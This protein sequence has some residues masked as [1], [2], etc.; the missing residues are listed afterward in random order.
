VAQRDEPSYADLVYEVLQTAGQPLTFAEI[1]ENVSRRRPITTNNPKATI[2]TVLGQGKQLISLGD[3]WYGYLPHLVQGSLL[4][5]PLTE[6]GPGN[7]PLIYP[8]ELRQ[9][10]W[11]S[12]FESQKRRSTRAASMR[13]PNGVEVE[14]FL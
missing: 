12:F 1:F 3:G 5:Q 8:D 14:L 10:L 2:R 11:P 13:M 9:A 6:K 7:H 4:Q